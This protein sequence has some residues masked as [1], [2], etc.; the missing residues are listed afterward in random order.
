MSPSYG[1][2]MFNLNVS[3]IWNSKIPY[4]QMVI[5]YQFLLPFQMWKNMGEA[6]NGIPGPDGEYMV[7]YSA[8]LMT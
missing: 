7:T 4:V 6:P 3:S 5:I 2:D 1:I 8:I